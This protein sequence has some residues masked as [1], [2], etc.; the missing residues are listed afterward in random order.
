[1]NIDRID[2]LRARFEQDEAFIAD[3]SDGLLFTGKV[4]V[5]LIL[6]VLVLAYP[7]EPLP[8]NDGPGFETVTDGRG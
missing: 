2:R 5:A 3:L 6:V 1:M 8:V 7:A 4:L